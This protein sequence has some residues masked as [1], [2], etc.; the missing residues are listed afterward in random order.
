M[1]EL[2]PDLLEYS[3]GPQRVIVIHRDL[4]TSSASRPDHR[5][6]AHCDDLGTTILVKRSYLFSQSLA[7]F[8]LR[9]STP[10]VNVQN[11]LWHSNYQCLHELAILD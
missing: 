8:L 4:S 10:A 1:C 5:E 6:M 2:I 3:D 9:Q 7:R 11:L